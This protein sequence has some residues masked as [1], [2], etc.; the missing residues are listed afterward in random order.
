MAE[1][2][3]VFNGCSALFLALVGSS[4]S[5]VAGTI[6]S[7]I[8]YEFGFD[9]NHTPFVAGC[10]PADAAGVP[11][12]PGVGTVNLDSP[13]WTFTSST[14]VAFLITDGLL[15]GDFFDV[16][17]LG[18]P[19]GS[20][21]AVPLSGP[22]CGLDPRVCITNVQ[23]SHASF[24]LPAGAHSITISAHAAQILGEGFFEFTLVPEPSSALLVIPGLLWIWRRQLAARVRRRQWIGTEP[25]V[26]RTISS[27]AINGALT[28]I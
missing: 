17:D 13:A 21:P 27:P 20:T 1:K 8:W 9:P 28:R 2:R 14:P 5:G 24:V 10:L 4:S 19:I 16:F 25:G 26:E 3:S 18:T 6:T 12:R 23:I 7:N 11:C 22:S 15:A